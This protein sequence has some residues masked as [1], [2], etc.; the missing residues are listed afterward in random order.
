MVDSPSRRLGYA[1]DSQWYGIEAFPDYVRSGLARL[2]RE[3]VNA[4]IRRH[5]QLQHIQYVYISKDT[6]DLAERLRGNQPSPMSYN[7]DKSAELLAEDA[8]IQQI[9]LGLTGE[10]VRTVDAGVMFE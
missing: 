5:L 3:Q 8:Q 4:A 2:T 10:R 6:A 7:S 9:D 1:L